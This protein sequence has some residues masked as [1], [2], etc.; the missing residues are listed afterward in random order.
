MC[1]SKNI[2]TESQSPTQILFA[3][4]DPIVCPLLNVAILMETV[5]SD[6]GLMFGR[7]NKTAANLLKQVYASAFFTLQR[8]GKLG[9]H[10]MR[11]VR[12]RLRFGCHKDWINQ[13]GRW[14]GGAPQVDTYID[15][16]QLYPDARVA[17]VL[18]GPRGP[19]KYSV[20]EGMV[21]P[22]AFLEWIVPHSI[23]VFGT[24]IAQV[25]A[26]P[27]LSH[28]QWCITSYHPC[29]SRQINLRPLACIWIQ[30][31]RKPC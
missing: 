12:Q 5:G 6:A 19:C 9:T 28:L 23:E 31:P 18:C 21:V 10:S 20:K 30:W 22:P 24:N 17:G 2:R 7:S 4:M 15:V 26:L 25:L 1:W 27:L 8:P 29:R 11:R 13:R 16:F 14:R 3:A